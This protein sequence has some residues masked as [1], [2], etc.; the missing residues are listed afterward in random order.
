[1]MKAPTLFPEVDDDS[2]QQSPAANCP[3]PFH[4][5]TQPSR[6]AAL[7]ARS[8]VRSQAVRV[9][10]YIASQGERGATDKEIQTALAMDGNSQRPRRVWLRNNGFV[11]E[12]GHPQEIVIRDGSTVWVTVRPFGVT[13]S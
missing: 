6:A 3:E 1:M 9:A 8:F 7:S 5:R 10:E 12:K 2:S 4:N 13:S 11:Q